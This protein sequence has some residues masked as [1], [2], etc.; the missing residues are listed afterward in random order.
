MENSSI[1]CG[2]A[3]QYVRVLL[4]RVPVCCQFESKSVQ[5]V[6]AWL[7]LLGEPI[8]GPPSQAVALLG[9]I[10]W[11]GVRGRSLTRFAEAFSYVS[12][13]VCFGEVTGCIAIKR[14]AVSSFRHFFG[15][16]LQLGGHKKA[17]CVMA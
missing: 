7:P 1:R 9:L 17:V 4:F 3:L 6:S 8:A 11:A 2:R 5:W 14:T 15:A 16:C 12:S 10:S 13:S